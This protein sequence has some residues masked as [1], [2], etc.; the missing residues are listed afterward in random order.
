MSRKRISILI[1]CAV[2]MVIGP[3]Y[4]PRAGAAEESITKNPDHGQAEN[5][6]MVAQEEPQTD[7]DP[8]PEADTATSQGL[9]NSA[10]HPNIVFILTDDLSLDLLQYMPHVLEM[11]KE[12]ATFNN[13]FVTDS[14]CCPSRSS[15]FTGRFP[16]D[17]GVFR[18]TGSDGGYRVF[19]D[20]GNERVTF[21]VSLSEAGYRTAM[22][23]KYLNGYIPAIDPVSPGWSHWA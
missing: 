7:P 23:G 1:F 4:M 18:N 12:G 15:I 11:Q 9:T 10:K 13:Y 8:A 19:R 5:S 21:A 16:H 22:L 6:R 2:L 17:T 3:G 14:L 20:R